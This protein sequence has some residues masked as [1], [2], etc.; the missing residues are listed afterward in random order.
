MHPSTTLQVMD[1]LGL[2]EGFLK[3]PHQRLQRMDGMFGGT[4]VRIADLGRLDAKF[5]YIAF[6]PQWDFLNFLRDSGKRFASLKVMMSAE[7]TD[8]IRDGDRIAG[9]R[10]RTAEGDIQRMQVAVQNNIVNAALKPG[11]A[12]LKAPAMLRLVTA[13]PWLQGI[14]ARFIGLG[15]RP[16]HVQSPLTNHQG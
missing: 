15:V 6:M 8:L 11:H 3:L 10:A 12:P 9:V 2:S 13:I 4:R 7:A 1:E 16:E 5:P 14:T